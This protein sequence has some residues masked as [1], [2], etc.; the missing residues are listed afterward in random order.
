MSGQ[1]YP[2]PTAGALIFNPQGE[3]FLMKSYKW[4]N[5]FV[6]P[7]GHVQL[8]ET[9]EQTLKREIREETGLDIYDIRFLCFHE[10]ILKKYFWQKRH[11]LFFDYTC[12]TKSTKVKLNSE[13]Q[14]YVWINPKGALKLSVEP[15]TRKTIEQYLKKS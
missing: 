4:K 12:K 3:I 2:E 11:F 5:K 15:Y 9:L 7:G 14:E 1:Q 13:G 10:F 6:M 8:G